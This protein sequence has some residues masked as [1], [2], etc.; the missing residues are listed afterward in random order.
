[1]HFSNNDSPFRLVEVEH[2]HLAFSR[3]LLAWKR[4]SRHTV[5]LS[6][7]LCVIDTDLCQLDVF[8][9]HYGHYQVTSYSPISHL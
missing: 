6:Q 4:N 5:F 9:G 3:L 8:M 1:M 2:M 7:K